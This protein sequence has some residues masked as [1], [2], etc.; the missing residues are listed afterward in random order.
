MTHPGGAI[1]P[2]LARRVETVIDRVDALPT[3][4][5]VA[6]RLL[7]AGSSEKADIG[8][9][10]SIIESDPAMSTRILGLCRRADRGLGDRVRTVRHAVVM[11]GLDAVRSAALSVSVYDLMN[12]EGQA[13][14]EALDAQLASEAEP[15]TSMQN[16]DRTGFWKHAVAVGC[17]AELLVSQNSRL[18]VAPEEAFLAGL[19]HDLGKLVLELVLP[20]AYGQVVRLAESRAVD[21]AEIE[22]GVIGLDH[23]EVGKRIAEHWNLPVPIR[24]VIWLHSK[25]IEVLPDVPHRGLIGLVT[26]SEA[27]CRGLHLGFACD[28]GQPLDPG[29]LWRD[30]RL[31]A[32]GA[33]SIIQPLHAALSDRLRVLGL[34]A[35]AGPT[36]LLESLANANRRLARLNTSLHERARTA[37]VNGRVHEAVTTFQRDV[38]R[39]RG[40]GEVMAHVGLS[41]QTLLGGACPGGLYRPA[42]DEPWQLLRFSPDGE[43]VSACLLAAPPGRGRAAWEHASE[44]TLFSMARLGLHSWLSEH[45][46]DV[47]ELKRLKLMP[48][49]A[50]DTFGA[51]AVLLTSA[52]FES[53]GLTPG[54]VHPLA[55]AWAACTR[56]AGATE[57]MARLSKQLGDSARRVAQ[58]EATLA[59]T[60]AASELGKAAAESV[61]QIEPALATILGRARLLQARLA[62]T[63]DL[64]SIGAIVDSA[65]QIAGVLARLHERGLVP[66]PGVTVETVQR[67]AGKTAA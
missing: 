44:P 19:L 53:V 31:S 26:L 7:S 6:A 16:F 37:Q 43:V 29:A 52:D 38:A 11:L 24:D 40:V 57:A 13:A 35:E 34:D 62:D 55:A 18:G 32:K 2:E 66:V 21:A 41:A 4:S 56:A 51:A 28:F 23:H 30:L 54:L 20:R 10:V 50:G 3:L 5:P 60:Q 42:P 12:R 25:P 14:R 47:A 61:E 33:D 1:D 65:N 17:C 22:R 8:G 48:L 27:I 45:L 64:A 67:G 63:Q 46:G 15:S 49:I 59:R 36:L 58:L 9:V 39:A